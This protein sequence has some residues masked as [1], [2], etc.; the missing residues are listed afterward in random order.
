[1]VHCEAGVSRSAAVVVAFLMRDEGLPFD[2][3]YARVRAARPCIS[4]NLGFVAQLQEY[5][6]FTASDSVPGR[7][8]VRP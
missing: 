4:P 3:A 5:R 2:A 8:A 6:G 7:R 1:M